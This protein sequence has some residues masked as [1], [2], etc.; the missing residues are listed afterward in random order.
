MTDTDMNR[1][2]FAKG[3]ALTTAGAATVGCATTAQKLNSPVMRMTKADLEFITS[4]RA[5]L[6][7]SSGTGTG[8]SDCDNTSVHCC[9]PDLVRINK[10][11]AGK[12]ELNIGGIS[13]PIDAVDSD[14]Q[15]RF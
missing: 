15:V 5:G 2:A 8:T 13:L 9:F 10:V 1:R 11:S 7:G 6:M 12:F 4:N 14:E 3:A